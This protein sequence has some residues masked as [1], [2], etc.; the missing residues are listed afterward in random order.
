[1]I[2]FPFLVKLH[3]LTMA[4]QPQEKNGLP[5]IAMGL[6]EVQIQC[7][8]FGTEVPLD[9]NPLA[10][11]RGLPGPQQIRPVAQTRRAGWREGGG[12]GGGGNNPNLNDGNKNVASR[13]EISIFFS[14]SIYIVC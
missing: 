12:G 8:H 11:I 1:M 2:C 14:L 13:T 3:R 4:R 9:H 6:F 7:V 10:V 5:P